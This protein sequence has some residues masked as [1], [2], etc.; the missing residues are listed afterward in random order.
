MS[1]E[2][3]FLKCENLQHVCMLMGS[4]QQMSK[5]RMLAI[6]EETTARVNFSLKKGEE[7]R[8]GTREG[9]LD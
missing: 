8:S 3:L 2:V 5:Q 1:G 4:I 7:R 9:G 6:E